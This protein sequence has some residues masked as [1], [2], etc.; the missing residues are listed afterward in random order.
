MGRPH[1]TLAVTGSICLAVAARLPGTVVAQLA[2]P[3]EREA[4]RIGHPA[5]ALRVE[6]SIDGETIHRAAIERTA[7]RILEGTLYVPASVLAQS[8]A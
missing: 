5:G 1:R 4:V 7:R 8:P 6:I 3:R 2:L